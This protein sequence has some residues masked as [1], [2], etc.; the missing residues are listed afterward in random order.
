MRKIFTYSSFF[1]LTT[2]SLVAVVSCNQSAEKKQKRTIV[3]NLDSSQLSNSEKIIYHDSIEYEPI[4]NI[5]GDTYN[6]ILEESQINWFCVTHTGYTKFNRG[7]L[8]FADGMII[9]GNFEICMDSISDIDIDYQ[10][11]KEVLEN[12]LKSEDFF[13]ITKFPLAHFNV[14]RVRENSD[15]IYEVVGNLT[16]KDAT[17]QIR[18]NSTIQS[19]DN[20]I[21]IESERFTIDRT[22]WG[23]TIY[24]ENFEQTDKSFLFTDM[25]DIQISLQ[26]VKEISK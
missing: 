10:L 13:D 8:L 25:V 9:K 17:R 16:I 19:E 14:V 26:L 22:K 5:E 15:N 12:T 1:I 11:M 2:V 18:F 21:I 20:L 6:I 3:E 7:Q 23:I 4:N 24:S